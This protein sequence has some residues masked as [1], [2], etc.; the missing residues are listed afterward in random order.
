MKAVTS[1]YVNWCLLSCVKSDGGIKWSETLSNRLTQFEIYQHL[2]KGA[3]LTP[4]VLR[5]IDVYD[6]I[7]YL[8]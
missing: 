5:V 2:H 7:S 8:K 1:S 6:T 3:E 4:K